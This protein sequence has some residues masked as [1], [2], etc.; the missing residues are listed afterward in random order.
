MAKIVPNIGQGYVPDSLCLSI[1]RA[2]MNKSIIPSYLRVGDCIAIV[3]TARW[4][5]S[6]QVDMAV[7]LLESWGFK[8]LV[9]KSIETRYGQLAGDDETRCSEL[10]RYLDDPEVSAILMARGGYGTVRILDNLDWSKFNRN[11]KW[12]CGYSDITVLL[13]HLVNKGIS[14]IHSTMP[15]SF[16]DATNVALEELRRCLTGE[17]KRIEWEKTEWSDNCDSVEG[18][19]IGGNLSVMNSL[20]GSLTQIDCRE[21]I[22]FIEDVDEHLYH[23]D[24]MCWALRRAGVFEG[25]KALII[26]GMTQMKDNTIA[27]GFKSDNPWGKEIHEIVRGSLPSSKIPIMGGFPAGHQSDNRAFIMGKPVI[28]KTSGNLASIEYI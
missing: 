8:V 15:I 11:P 12:I 6:G 10:Q 25:L 18:R 7:N 3:A 16:P 13:A 4:M 5:D 24:R 28:L 20:L 1:L 21:S 17:I 9:S 23:L 14:C 27:F 26:G 22:L 2:I 19:L